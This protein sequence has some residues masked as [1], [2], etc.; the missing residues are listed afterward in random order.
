MKGIRCDVA[1][2]PVSGTY[3]M[4]AEEAAK[5]CELLD[6]A[7]AVP[8]HW[9]EHVGT[10]DDARRFVA[11]CGTPAT[12]LPRERGCGRPRAEAPLMSA[13]SQRRQGAGQRRAPRSAD[14]RLDGSSAD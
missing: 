1:L 12:L 5:A 7:A 10:E 3:T 6:A 9:G 2:L 11:Q 8:M 4:T 14:G 13:P